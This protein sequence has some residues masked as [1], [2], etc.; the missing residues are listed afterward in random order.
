[1]GYCK[2]VHNPLDFVSQSHKVEMII[3]LT[4]V[5]FYAKTIWYILS[6]HGFS[7]AEKNSIHYDLRYRKLQRVEIVAI[8]A[9]TI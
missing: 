6:S 3:I 1:M 4:K 2:L 5:N 8:C 9:L 7:L